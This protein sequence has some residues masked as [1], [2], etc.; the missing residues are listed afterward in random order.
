MTEGGDA[1]LDLVHFSV[2]PVRFA[3]MAEQVAWI[4]EEGEVEPS[5]ATAI[6][7]II[8]FGPVGEPLTLSAVLGVR[9]PSGGEAP[10]LVGNLDSIE[11]TRLKE[12]RP[13]P[14]LVEKQ[15]LPKGIWAAMRRSGRFTLLLDLHKLMNEVGFIK[16]AAK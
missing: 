2:G 11:R 3:V 1:H 16:K 4:G 9:G 13:L 12:I 15:A 14:P 8:D 7:E 6:T 10:L 5:E